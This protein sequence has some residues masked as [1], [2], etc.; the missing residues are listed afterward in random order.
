MTVIPLVKPAGLAAADSDLYDVDDITYVAGD[1]MAAG[2]PSSITGVAAA[3][4]QEIYSGRHPAG[5]RFRT[6]EDI[7]TEHGVSAESAG[8]ALRMLRAEGLVTLEQGRGTY[9]CKLSDYRVTVRAELPPGPP[10]ADRGSTSSLVAVRA[11]DPSVRRLRRNV[12]GAVWEWTMTLR[13]ADAGRAAGA[14]LA[15][16]RRTADSG[17]WDFTRASVSAE[18]AGD[19]ETDADRVTGLGIARECDRGAN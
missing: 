17:P 4:R 18:L 6:R 14:G 16:A 5:A 19:T 8:V 3:L 2:E 15:V 12:R 9:V 7:A 1:P 10:P 13:A 11:A